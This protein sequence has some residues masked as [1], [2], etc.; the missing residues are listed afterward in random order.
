M[1]QEAKRGCLIILIACI[2]L[3]SAIVLIFSAL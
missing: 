1:K 3:W 2:I